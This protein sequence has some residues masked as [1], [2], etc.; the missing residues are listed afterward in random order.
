[1]LPCFD[2]IFEL[3]EADLVCASNLQA[4]SEHCLVGGPPF[5]KSWIAT[6]F[7]LCL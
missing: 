3:P 4:Q 7:C 6:G 1:M 2:V 5:L